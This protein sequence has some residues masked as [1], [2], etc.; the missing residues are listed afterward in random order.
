LDTAD[1]PSADIIITSLG[2]DEA[3]VS[4]YEEL[5]AGQEVSEA[6]KGVADSQASEG[7]GDGIVPGGHGRTTIFIDTSTVSP[8]WSQ[9]ALYCLKGGKEEGIDLEILVRGDGEFANGLAC[10]LGRLDAI[11]PQ[12]LWQIRPISPACT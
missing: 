6:R 3:V 8:P 4:V 9:L 7:K 10:D 1:H 2:N 11:R 5:F 12:A